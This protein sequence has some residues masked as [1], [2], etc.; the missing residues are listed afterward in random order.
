MDAFRPDI[1]FGPGAVGPPAHPVIVETAGRC[2]VCRVHWTRTPTA[3][4]EVC[5]R[6]AAWG[7]IV[8]ILVAQRTLARLCCLADPDIPFLAGL[9]AVAY[10]MTDR[11][12]QEDRARRDALDEQRETNRQAA[13]AYSQGRMDAQDERGW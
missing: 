10:L 1:L 13:D 12:R 11:K 8:M 2:Q 6:R 7:I 9:D 5:Q 4:C 3:G